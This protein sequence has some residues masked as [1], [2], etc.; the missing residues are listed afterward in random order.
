MYNTPLGD[1][2][3]MQYDRET[4][5]VTTKESRWGSA[6]RPTLSPD[7]KWLVYGTRYVD[8][9]R[10]RVRDLA[11][12]EDEWL[13]GP[14][15]RDDQE[16]I[17]SLDV[18]P[19]MSFTP[20]SK[21]LV[22]TWDGKFWKVAMDTKKATEIPFEADVVQALGPK[23]AFDYPDPRF[24]HVHD[25]ADSRRGAESRMAGA[26]RSWRSTGCT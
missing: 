5:Q 24:R 4:G 18:Y 16:S 3:L 15:Q 1:Y 17:A 11:T 21:F 13:T 25:Q 22:T 7:G 6:F 2:S 12:N 9:T 8:H 20:D 14:V 23:V 10:L 19:G 26:S